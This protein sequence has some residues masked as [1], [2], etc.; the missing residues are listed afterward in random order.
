[1]A[2]YALEKSVLSENS[3]TG[4]KAF[5]RWLEYLDET[6]GLEPPTSIYSYHA[7]KYLAE[8]RSLIWF[9][10]RDGKY[11]LTGE[12]RTGFLALLQEEVTAACKCQSEVLYPE[13]EPKP[14]CDDVCQE[15]VDSVVG[16]IRQMEAAE[17]KLRS[18]YEF[19]KE[20]SLNENY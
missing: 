2:K 14:S 12:E 20:I 4:L 9:V 8:T 16:Y 15:S 5:E 18:I 17:G 11:D 1:M 3:F 19:E 6:K 10:V 7:G 13:K